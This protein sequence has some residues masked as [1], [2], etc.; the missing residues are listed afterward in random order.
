MLSMFQARQDHWLDDA[1]DVF[2]GKLR[3]DGGGGSGLAD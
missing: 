2:L 3:K 1:I